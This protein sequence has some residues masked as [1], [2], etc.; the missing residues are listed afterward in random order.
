M[1]LVLETGFHGQEIGQ[2]WL[3]VDVGLPADLL[4]KR[5]NEKLEYEQI[6][7]LR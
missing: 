5:E 6:F 3:S 4:S 1:A 2:F 7:L